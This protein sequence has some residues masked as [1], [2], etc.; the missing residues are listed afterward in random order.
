MQKGCRL[1]MH[2]GARC[3]IICGWRW[4]VAFS[5][6]GFYWL[7][8]LGPLSWVLCLGSGPSTGDARHWQPHILMW[9]CLCQKLERWPVVAPPPTSPHSGANLHFLWRPQSTWFECS[10]IHLH[11]TCQGWHKN[12]NKIDQCPSTKSDIEILERDRAVLS[13]SD[14]RD[15]GGPP[16]AMLTIGRKHQVEMNRV[17]R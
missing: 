5:E 9:I 1:C 4:G 17:K 8:Y 7:L 10:P 16:I 3:R 11:T 13:Y 14:L 12:P 15:Q 6:E 2:Q